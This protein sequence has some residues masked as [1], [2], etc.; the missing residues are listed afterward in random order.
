MTEPSPGAGPIGV[1][2]MTFGS[3]VTAEQVPR[4]LASVRGDR[5]VPDELIG[6]FRDRFRTIGR[7]PLI[8]I[9][10]AQ[11]AALQSLLDTEHGGATYRVA[12]GM[13]HSEPTID[14][15]FSELAG[16]GV[17]FA[18]AIALAPQSSP[19]VLGNYERAV[20]RN[21]E[22]LAECTIRIAQP[23]HL[24]PALLESLVERLAAALIGIPADRRDTVPVVFTAHSVPEALADRDPGYVAQLHAT[25]DAVA[26]RLGMD[27]ERWQFAYQSAGRTSQR[28]LGPDL[29]DVL[30]A[31]HAEGHRDVLV[32]PVQFVADHLE[33]LYDLDVAA[34]AEARDIGMTLHRITMPNVSPTFIRALAAVVRRDTSAVP[35]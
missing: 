15:A 29:A 35:V 1:L 8:D 12:V 19:V 34:R 31:L 5:P 13:L 16:A 11:G 27:S 9:T 23:W 30:P 3:A 33:T 17:R 22:R 25:S 18:V 14:A 21:Q 7:S 2:L 32:A 10:R 6:E 24:L 20:R 26:A 28:W 4:Y